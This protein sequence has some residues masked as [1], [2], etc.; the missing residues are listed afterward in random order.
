MKIGL[1][2]L[3]TVLCFFAKAQSTIV[4]YYNSDMGTCA[5]SDAM[6]YRNITK[7]D[8]FYDSK[9]Y[10]LV[11]NKLRAICTYRDTFYYKTIGLSTDYFNNG[12]LEDSS[13]IDSS[14]AYLYKYHY[15]KNGKMFF[16]F[17][18]DPFKDTT[19]IIKAFDT[20]GNPIKDFVFEKDAEFPGGMGAWK[21]YLVSKLRNDFPKKYYKRRE[22]IVVK[23]VVRFMIDKDGNT[24]A[25]ELE[26]SSGIPEADENALKIIMKSP[27]WNYA[28]QYNRP[29]NAYK[30][31][32]L[33]Y[34]LQMD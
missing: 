18:G 25:V 27:K 10:W 6:Y 32:P 30:R 26:K 14:N 11:S 23:A 13:F 12:Q 20:T 1:I 3:F 19:I 17:N 21:D 33:T 9:T 16:Y 15:Y 4:K 5:K 24:S 7:R 34:M 8:T 31:Q 29:V 2:F 22:T 28:I